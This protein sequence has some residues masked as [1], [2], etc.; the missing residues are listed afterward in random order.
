MSLNNWGVAA[1]EAGCRTLEHAGCFDQAELCNLASVETLVRRLQLIEYYY[2]E[3]ARREEAGRQQQQGKG[4][5]IGATIEES[6]VFSGQN[7]DY[8]EC[9]VAPSLID[10]VAKEVERDAAIMKQIRK[11]REERALQRKSEQ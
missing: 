8:G 5:K 11:A 9:M 6:A 3:A 7:R 1:H 4:K 10:H 2:Y